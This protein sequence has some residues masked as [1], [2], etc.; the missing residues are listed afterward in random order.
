MHH[1]LLS[2]QNPGAR[3]DRSREGKAGFILTVSDIAELRSVTGE[4]AGCEAG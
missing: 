4:R 3:S 2:Y 1:N